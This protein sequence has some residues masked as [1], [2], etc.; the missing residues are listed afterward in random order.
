MYCIN[1]Y[2]H[3]LRPEPSLEPD[4]LLDAT[5][6]LRALLES[7]PKPV[8]AL[9][10]LNNT[11]SARLTS[12]RRPLRLRRDLVLLPGVMHCLP[13]GMEVHARAEGELIKL[14]PAFSSI[15]LD[16]VDM[17]SKVVRRV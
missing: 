10:G 12:R 9:L 5:G 16:T 11:R 6:V 2:T 1:F 14:G 7:E 3:L 8:A 13:V 15:G 4:N 17:T